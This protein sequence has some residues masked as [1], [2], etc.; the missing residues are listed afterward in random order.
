MIYE[1]RKHLAGALEAQSRSVREE[2][3]A[4]TSDVGNKAGGEDGTGGGGGG[5]RIERGGVEEENLVVVPRCW[6]CTE[7]C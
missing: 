2:F 3:V 5:R 7:R 6:C 1:D 4:S